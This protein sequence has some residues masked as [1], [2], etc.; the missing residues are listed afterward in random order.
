MY[1][2][3]TEEVIEKRML[4]SVPDTVD[5]RE[6]SVIYDAT[7]PTAIEVMLLYAMCDYFL[8]NT[9][10]DTAERSWLIERAKERSVVP[11]A[12]SASQVKLSFTPTALAVPIGSRFSYDDVNYA[13]TEKI[14]DG[15][16]YAICET[17]G[18][19][20]NKAAGAV[21][22]IDNIPGLQTAALTEVTVPGEDAEDT[23]VFRARYLAS[24]DSRA[25]GGNFADYRAKV[26]SLAGV[27]GVKVYPTWQGGGTVRL[28]IM[29]SEYGVPTAEF[30]NKIQT[31]VDPVPNHGQGLGIA[32]V[33]H[34]VTVQGVQN[35]AVDIDLTIVPLGSHTFDDFRV[36][37]LKV[38]DTYFAELNKAWQDTQKMEPDEIYNNGLLISRAR[39]E[40]RLLDIPGVRDVTR[41]AFNG[42][43]GNLELGPD[44]L[45]VRGKVNGI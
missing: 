38:I 33:G 45:A 5:K 29:T 10:G 43:E 6:G 2:S 1:E 40:S 7:K 3:Q 32:P 37:V 8:T 27:G 11:K 22:P 14:S 28:V 42:I 19:V 9:F 25:Y 16:Y 13:V 24:F 12:A 30:I 44:A 31:A 36:D 23:E 41:T 39:L 21:I 20:G 26:N 15:L 34:R 18:I 35:S 17:V 4:S